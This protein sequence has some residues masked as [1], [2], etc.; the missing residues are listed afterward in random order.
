MSTGTLVCAVNETTGA[1]EALRTAS[2]LCERLGM[3]LV[4]VHVLEDVPLSPAA[5]REARAGG[6]RLVDRLLAEQGVRVA[7][8][9][10]AIGDPAEHIGRI[11]GEE[12]AELILLG[13]KPNGRKPQPP[14]R[15]R[16]ATELP[17]RTPVPVVV[18]PPQ[19]AWRVLAMAD[20][21]VESS[22]V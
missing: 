21:D 10:V 22:A 7:D 4:A 20:R 2:R 13:S 6:M 18:V 11:A 8:R 15:S 17:Q 9:R 14:L 12:R 5:R 16:L 1:E 3:R 19:L